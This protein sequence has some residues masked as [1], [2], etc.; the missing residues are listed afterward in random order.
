MHPS[1]LLLFLSLAAL[2]ENSDGSSNWCYTGCSHSPSHWSS[3]GGNFCGGKSQSPIDIARAHAKTDDKLNDFT[4]SNFSSTHV[5]KSLSNNGHTVK[6]VLEQ[7]AAEVSGGGLN[8]TYSSIQFHFHWGDTEHHPGSEHMLD[9][10]RYPMEMHIVN[11]KKGLTAGEAMSNSEGIAVLGFF[12][13]ESDDATPSEAWDN[14]TS[15][16]ADIPNINNK[17][18]INHSISI[19]DLISGVDLTKFYRY[20]GSLTTP[21]CN[22]AVVWTVFQQPIKVFKSLIQRFPSKTGLKNLYRPTQ[23]LNGR[24]VFASPAIVPSHQ[25]CYNQHCAFSP[26]N[27]HNMPNSHCGGQQQ[28]PINLVVEDAVLDTNLTQFT[29]TKFDDKDAIKSVTNTGH[30]VK[31]EVKEGLEVSGGGL[32]H[33]YSTLQF[34]FHWGNLSGEDLNGSEHTVGSQRHRM[35]MHIVNKRKDLTLE[36]ALVASN[37]LAVLA[38][39]IEETTV[40]YPYMS[41]WHKLTSYLSHI[42][43][44]NNK[45]DVHSNI[46]IND[47][48]GNNSSTQYFRYHGSLTTPSC[49]EAVVW[50]VF[51]TPIGLEKALIEQFP[52]SMGYQS[53]YR[54]VQKLHARK[55]YTSSK[56]GM[57]PPVSTANPSKSSGP[58]CAGLPVLLV[59]CFCASFSSSLL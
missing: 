19:D 48:L 17:V 36:E 16:L 42:S 14:F 52:A 57:S 55:V 46:S 50:S 20:K 45:A 49:N 53:V 5:L 29:F 54:P 38:F 47:L 18:N 6:C 32:A 11:L 3:M 30:T 4:L 24:T 44:I 15:Y 28:S 27:W 35:E 12:I 31:Y 59:A 33:V 8:G 37:G 21:T 41:Y 1:F 10:H 13:T 2:I 58:G 26:A 39:F 23:V 40:Q 34:H 22:E 7:D 43:H 25:W 56:T 51:Y 9:G